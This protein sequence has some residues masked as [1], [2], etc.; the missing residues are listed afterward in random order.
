MRISCIIKKIGIDRY[1]HYLLHYKKELNCFIKVIIDNTVSF[2]ND[3]LFFD[4]KSNFMVKGV[5]TNCAS[6]IML[7]YKPVYD[8]FVFMK[9]RQNNMIFTTRSNM[10]E[11]AVGSLGNSSFFGPAYRL[12]NYMDSLVLSGGSSSGSAVSASGLIDFSIGSDTGGSCRLPAII[13][14]TIGFKP[15][16]GAIS[17]YGLVDYCSSLDTVG[18]LSNDIYIIDNVFKI[19][20]IIDKFDANTKLYVRHFMNKKIAILHFNL[21][22]KELLFSLKYVYDAL[23]SV[24]YEFCDFY[25]SDFIKID[26]LLYV[27]SIITSIEMYSNMNKFHF[28]NISIDFMNHI[29]SLLYNKINLGF[30]LSEYS[31]YYDKYITYLNNI[32][33]YFKNSFFDYDFFILPIAFG[34][35]CLDKIREMDAILCIANLLKF[36]SISIPLDVVDN[37]PISILFMSKNG[38]DLCLLDLSK[39]IYNFCNFNKKLPNYFA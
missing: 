21:F 5:E 24:G 33:T 9:L 20:N 4:L 36:P 26:E 29:G 32:I 3:S 25:V 12:Y 38:G 16:Y 18:I 35:F 7:E 31:I 13:C 39:H 15:S 34:R 28:N 30:Y 23:S 37:E 10:D 11:F 17:R 8:S 27:Y 6:K 2:N 14:G 19:L 1:I 22:E